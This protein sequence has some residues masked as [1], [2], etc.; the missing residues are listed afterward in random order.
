MHLF[1]TFPDDD[2]RILKFKRVLR[3]DNKGMQ[4]QA[5]KTI[6][7]LTIVFVPDEDGIQPTSPELSWHFNGTKTIY[8]SPDQSFMIVAVM[9]NAEAVTPR[10]VRRRAKQQPVAV[11]G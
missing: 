9:I 7:N 11:A 4:W 1:R 5:R 10:C 2:R 8:Q 3:R 6:G